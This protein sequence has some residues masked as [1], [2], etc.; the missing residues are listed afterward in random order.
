MI[1]LSILGR[2]DEADSLYE[3]SDYKDILKP[4]YLSLKGKY[5]E[6]RDYYE[7]KFNEKESLTVT[8]AVSYAYVM[9]HCEDY[10]AVKKLEAGDVV[11]VEGFLYWYEGVNPHITS[12]TVR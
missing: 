9:L 5:Q 10:Q 8:E 7:N 12:V 4:H 6:E 11:D 1:I 2:E 3:A